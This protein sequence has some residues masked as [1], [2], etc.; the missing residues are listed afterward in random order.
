MCPNDAR[1]LFGYEVQK[2]VHSELC[3]HFCNA[4][5]GQKD[6]LFRSRSYVLNPPSS[7]IEW[8]RFDLNKKEF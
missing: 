4:V 8:P 3:N 5:D 7:L 1:F 2:W 6:K